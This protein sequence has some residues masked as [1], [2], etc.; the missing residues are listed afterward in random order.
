MNA[1]QG[2]HNLA[3]Q[4]AADEPGDMFEL[5][6]HPFIVKIWLEE[7]AQEAGR[8]TWRGH[9]THVPSGRRR[10]LQ[11][12]GDILAFIIPYLESMGVRIKKRWRVA[13]WLKWWNSDLMKQE[14][15][16]ANETR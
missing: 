2:G 3:P 9:I 1:H 11:D 13:E 5:N 16:R 12:L 15:T 6:T 4:Q 7:T 8:A 14:T 10:Y